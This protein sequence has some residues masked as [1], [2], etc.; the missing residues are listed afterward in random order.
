MNITGYHIEFLDREGNLS[1]LVLD[2][3]SSGG[4]AIAS[5]MKPAFP[6]KEAAEIYAKEYGLE[7]GVTVEITEHQWIG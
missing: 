2:I 3:E 6:T 4:M 1:G 5:K 7:I